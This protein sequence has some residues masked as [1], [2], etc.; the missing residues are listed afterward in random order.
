MY[1]YYLLLVSE[2]TL[3]FLPDRLPPLVEAVQKSWLAS[4][5]SSTI[6]VSVIPKIMLW[7]LFDS[8][9]SN[10]NTYFGPPLVV[11]QEWYIFLWGGWRWPSFCCPYHTFILFHHPKHEQYCNFHD[12]YW[13]AWR[14]S[15]IRFSPKNICSRGWLVRWRLLGTFGM[16]R[17]RKIMDMDHVALWVIVGWVIDRTWLK[18]VSGIFTLTTGI[19]CLLAEIMLYVWIVESPTTR[20]FMLCLGVF[21]MMPMLQLLPL[22]CFSSNTAWRLDHRYLWLR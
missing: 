3:D 6:L 9:V 8:L 12:T 4:C 10:V 19:W 17:Y 5:G 18:F 21:A 14:S 1:A 2:Q 15:H 16:F 11:L 13:Q 20:I 22:H 7:G